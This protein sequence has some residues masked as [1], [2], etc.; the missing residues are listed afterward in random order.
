M[1]ETLKKDLSQVTLP[2]LRSVPVY[3][4][5]DYINFKTN[6]QSIFNAIDVT[7]FGMVKRKLDKAAHALKASAVVQTILGVGVGVISVMNTA[8]NSKITKLL[9]EGDM[10]SEIKEDLSQLHNYFSDQGPH[11]RSW[12]VVTTQNTFGENH[13]VESLKDIFTS[14]LELANKDPTH[15][16]KK[17]LIHIMDKVDEFFKTLYEIDYKLLNAIFVLGFSGKDLIRLIQR[18]HYIFDLY[19]LI[20]ILAGM[21]NE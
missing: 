7:K 8:I 6:F 4:L 16:S 11:K 21:G 12:M 19:M 14:F 5:D 3:A 20:Y 9:K 13:I 10:Y 2:V 15:D 17:D 18:S 1:L